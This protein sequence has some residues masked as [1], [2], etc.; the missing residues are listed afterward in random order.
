MK[1]NCYAVCAFAAAT[2]LTVTGCS[3]KKTVSGTGSSIK[4]ITIA[5][6]SQDGSLDPAGF[7]L[8]SWVSFSKLCSVPLLSYDKSGTE[9][10]EAAESYTVSDDN[11]TWTFK[12]RP[13]GKWSDGS[14]VTAGDFINTV[15]RALDPSNS[16]S[17]YGEQLY[18]IAG[19]EAAGS[20][21]GSLENV[22]VSAPDD[23]TLV[24]HLT[25]PCP[26]FKKLLALP[27]YYPSKAGVA[28][29]ANQ[30]WYKDP[31][32][33][34]CNGAYKLAEFIQ[35]QSITVEKNPYYYNKDKVLIEKIKIQYISDSQA[36]IAAYESGEVNV[37]T[38]L[39]DYIETKY[40]GKPD[41]SIWHMLTTTALLPNEKVKPLDDVRVRQALAL[42][43]NRT[44]I[45]TAM[46]KNYEP[47]YS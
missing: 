14:Q 33:C 43:L 29:A 46:G 39:P 17:I 13:E 24:F 45:C 28:T 2:L 9:I 31:S 11:L 32:T 47:S 4:E 27:V 30:N 23:L 3:G 7:A 5:E 19:A 1:R 10:M 26:Y 18:V 35:D 37:V 40:A 6:D 12:L 8:A 36:R 20:G 34:L 22:G 42:A 25:A 16:N 44:D 38:G 41:L 15:R 21:K